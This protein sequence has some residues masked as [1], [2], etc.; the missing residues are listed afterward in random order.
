MWSIL[1]KHFYSL[2]TTQKMTQ[3]YMVATEVLGCSQLSVYKL[4]GVSHRTEHSNHKT[5]TSH[6]TTNTTW[7]VIDECTFEV[8]TLAKLVT[9]VRAYSKFRIAKYV[10]VFNHGL[11]G[12]IRR[13]VDGLI[14]LVR[15][16]IPWVYI[17]NLIFRYAVLLCTWA[18][19]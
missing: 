7:W 10:N 8:A 16:L 6:S 2:K 15:W 14:T 5:R 4:W 18:I 19:H 3:A 9:S 11:A 12:T 17:V 1:A 13:N